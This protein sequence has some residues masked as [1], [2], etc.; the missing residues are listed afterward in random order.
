ME[1]R[2]PKPAPPYVPFKTFLSA[3]ENLEHGIPNQIDRSVWPSYSGAIQGQLLATL[4]F[5][6]LIDDR[7]IPQPSLHELIENKA[8]RKNKLAKIL[9]HAYPDLFALNLAKVSPKQLDDAV[10]EYGVTGATQRKALAFLLRAARY[11]DL[12]LSP[13]LKRKT[14]ESGGT[15][16]RRNG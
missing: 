3:I 7:G 11:A 5:L 16:R 9:E 4:M 10:A 6:G 8:N 1:E 12:P 2:K 13:L 15:R 14:R